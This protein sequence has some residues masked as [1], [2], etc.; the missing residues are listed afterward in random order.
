[1]SQSVWDLERTSSKWDS[2]FRKLM[3]KDECSDVVFIIKNTSASVSTNTSTADINSLDN[4]DRSTRD[5]HHRIHG[6][7]ALF[8]AHSEVLDKMLFGCMIESKKSNDVIIHD[9]SYN[10]FEWLKQYVYH[11]NPKISVENVVSIL[12]MSDKYMIN[13]VTDACI[14]YILQVFGQNNSDQHKAFLNI[15]FSLSQCQM[16]HTTA[17]IWTRFNCGVVIGKNTPH[18]LVSVITSPH[19]IK[20]GPELINQ[21]IDNTDIM[22]HVTTSDLSSIWNGLLQYCNSIS[23]NYGGKQLQD[24]VSIEYKH[25]RDENCKAEKVDDVDDNVKKK[26]QKIKQNDKMGIEIF[27]KY[28]VSKFD[29]TK[30]EQSFFMEYIYDQKL[31]S[32]AKMIQVLANFVLQNHE[33][34]NQLQNKVNYCKETHDRFEAWRKTPIQVPQ[35]SPIDTR[36]LKAMMASKNMKRPR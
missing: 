4:D 7:R 36:H 22:T 6:I 15:L 19:L 20:L 27:K 11:C 31:L 14:E 1:M 32:D 12:Q 16:T 24:Y 33:N 29:F 25:E 21:M 13:S 5:G 18:P 34:I 28:F 10:Q 3:S 17:K 23:I 26:E 30:M 8:A 9:L 35:I 2:S